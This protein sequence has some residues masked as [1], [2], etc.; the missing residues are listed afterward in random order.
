M[1]CVAVEEQPASFPST[2]DRIL[3]NRRLAFSVDSYLLLGRD[4]GDPCRGANASHAV[5]LLFL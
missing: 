1:M 4:E 2:L 3:C 5:Q